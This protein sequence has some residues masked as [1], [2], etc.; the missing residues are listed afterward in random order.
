MRGK[1]MKQEKQKLQRPVQF[2]VRFNRNERRDLT[3]LAALL[4]RSQN[5]AACIAIAFLKR[6][7]KKHGDKAVLV[8]PAGST[9]PNIQPMTNPN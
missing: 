3:E 7:I 8:F 2:I 1:K 4:K 6:E 5:D 9:L